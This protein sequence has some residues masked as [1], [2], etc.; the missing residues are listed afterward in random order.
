MDIVLRYTSSTTALKA[1]WGKQHAMVRQ[2]YSQPKPGYNLV[3]SSGRHYRVLLL[4]LSPHARNTCFTWATEGSGEHALYQ[5]LSLSRVMKRGSRLHKCATQTW[6]IIVCIT[7]LKQ[8]ES[9]VYQDSISCHSLWRIRVVL[10][11]HFHQISFTNFGYLSLL[12]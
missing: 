2:V 9:S 6:H 5:V 12:Y 4:L 11:I 1:G 7:H 3:A 10:F 8:K